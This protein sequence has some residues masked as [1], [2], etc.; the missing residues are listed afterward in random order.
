MT[1]CMEEEREVTCPECRGDGCIDCEYTGTV[2][3]GGE[4][5][6][7]RSTVWVLM[8]WDGGEC[9]HPLCAFDREPS[10]WDRARAWVALADHLPWAADR[11]H[12]RNQIDVFGWSRS[13]NAVPVERVS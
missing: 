6:M 4:E 11:D 8:A 5:V 13:L 2:V 1:W 7:S 10:W 12:R 3:I 9:W